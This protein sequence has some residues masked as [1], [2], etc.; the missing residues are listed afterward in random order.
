MKQFLKSII[1][2][3][4]S[5]KLS[6]LFKYLWDIILPGIF[7]IASFWWFLRGFR[8]PSAQEVRHVCENVTF[9]YKSFERQN[10]A[11]RLYR[12]I[13][14][15]YPG[16]KVVIADDSKKPLSMQAPYLTIIHLPF[17]S[18]LSVGLNSALDEVTTPYVFRMDD[19]E[20]LTPFTE[21]GKQVLFL[22]KNPQIDLVGVQAI[23]LTHPKKPEIC[24]KEYIRQSMHNAPKK[25][26]I[27]HMT[28]LDDVHYVVGKC[29]NVFLCRTEKIKQIGYDNQ[30]RMIDHNEFFYRAAGNLVSAMDI[31][32]W[33]FHYHNLFD[34]QYQKYRNDCQG[35]VKYIRAKHSVNKI[36]MPDREKTQ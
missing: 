34:M 10:M 18:G 30:I 26:L 31:S 14:R 4:N 3:I 2:K 15:F 33:V 11:K 32:A 28:Q 1:R 16:V 5:S 29:A 21:I 24:A 13:Q 8:K 35:D 27:P 17:N 12:N 9:I 7:S 22:E 36:S 20:L 25:L 6:I 23:Q 19:D